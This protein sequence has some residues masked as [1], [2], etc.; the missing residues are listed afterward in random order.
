MGNNMSK[1]SFTLCCIAPAVAV[2]LAFFILPVSL[3][4]P[5]SL[6]GPEGAG[7]YLQIITNP[8]YWNSLVATVL[9]SLA[10]TLVALA[11]G[12]LSGIFLERHRFRG[13]DLVVSMLTLPLSFPGVVVGFMIIMLAGRQ[14]IIGL[15]TNASS[16]PSWSLPMA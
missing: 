2:F 10:V 9:L 8:H 5:Q 15:G 11:V 1:Q 4:V 14:G 7:L 3:L 6:S 12:G 16:A 13:R